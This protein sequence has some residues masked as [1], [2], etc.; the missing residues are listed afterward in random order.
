MG[1]PGSSTTIYSIPKRRRKRFRALTG[2]DVLGAPRQGT[3][4]KATARSAPQEA[5]ESRPVEGRAGI[6]LSSG[7]DIAV[8]DDIGDRVAPLQRLHQQG[9]AVVLPSRIRSAVCSFEFNANGEVI[10]A[11]PAL[12]S[13][14]PGVPGTPLAAD[15]LQQESVAADKKVRRHPKPPQFGVVRR[16]SLPEATGEKPLDVVA[17][18]PS[19]RQADA[20]Q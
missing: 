19:R 10:A 15:E 3:A 4:A 2:V 8:A 13:R 18:E 11:L 7:S 6:C 5:A 12:P 9:K 16:V 17:G 20:V 14:Y 1:A